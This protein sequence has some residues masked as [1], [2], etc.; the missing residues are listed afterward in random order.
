MSVVG[1]DIG[2]QK[3]TIGV[4]KGGGIEIVLNEESDRFTP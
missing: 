3:C 1:F 2:T 4:A